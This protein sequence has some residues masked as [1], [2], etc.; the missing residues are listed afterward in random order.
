MKKINIIWTI[1]LVLFIAVVFLGI[2]QAGRGADISNL[3]DRLENI[4]IEK[5]DLT[6]DI[7]RSG[8]DTKLT[9]SALEF[10]FTKPSEVL[11]FN[12][13]DSVASIK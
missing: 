13:I 2:E 10:G 9:D 12:S 11:Y 3:E 1:N 7:F 5:R 8:S 4:S 6:E